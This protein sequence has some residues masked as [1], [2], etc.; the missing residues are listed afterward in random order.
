MIISNSE[1]HKLQAK[2]NPLKT[3]DVYI[4]FEI[5]FQKTANIH[6]FKFEF[7]GAHIFKFS[8]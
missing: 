2:M 3:V 5:F 7:L 8:F 6:I 4:R 1:I